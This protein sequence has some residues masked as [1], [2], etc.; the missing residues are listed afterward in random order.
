MGGCWYSR[1]FNVAASLQREVRLLN[2]FATRKSYYM[3]K[4]VTDSGL[5]KLGGFE[6]LTHSR[7]LDDD[8]SQT[9]TTCRRRGRNQVL[10][11]LE[12]RGRGGTP[13]SMKNNLWRH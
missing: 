7:T 9:Y 5:L 2:N 11:R 1:W 4:K 10:D 6:A 3:G 12:G 8:L 13:P